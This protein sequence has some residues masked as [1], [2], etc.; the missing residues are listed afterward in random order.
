LTSLRLAG[1]LKSASE[2][3]PR[4]APC[5]SPEIEGGEHKPLRGIGHYD[6]SAGRID[7]EG[8]SVAARRRVIGDS[9]ANNGLKCSPAGLRDAHVADGA[10]RGQ[11]SAIRHQRDLGALPRQRASG[12]RVLAVQNPGFERVGAGER[13][14][15]QRQETIDR[16]GLRLGTK[17]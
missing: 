10:I 1:H 14:A 11:I 12:F 9:D 15:E 8:V 2:T 5:G 6:D 4:G 3:V 17:T 16:E 7:G 13:R